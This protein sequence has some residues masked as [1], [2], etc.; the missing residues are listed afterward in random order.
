VRV[1]EVRV[2]KGAGVVASVLL[3]LGAILT[4]SASRRPSYVD[5]SGHVYERLDSGERAAVIGAVVSNDWDTTTATTNV[6]G[7]FRLRVRRVAPDEFM[8]FTARDGEA[9]ACH[10]R[11]GSL[12]SI[13]VDIIL[14]V[15]RRSGGCRPD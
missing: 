3:S 15:P 9:A 13:P 2:R 12:E 5:I 8:K 10:L 11:V 4:L 14:N 1:R 6:L 7:E